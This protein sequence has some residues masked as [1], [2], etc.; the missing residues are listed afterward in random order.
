MP[1]IIRTRDC[2]VHFK[3]DAFPVA[4]APEMLQR[5]WPGS[6]GVKWA[7]STNDEFCVTYSDGRYGGFLLWGS[8][9]SSD[10][11]TALTGQQVACGH[12]VFCMGGWLISTSTYEKYTYASRMGGGPLVPIVYTASRR[13]VFSLRGFWTIEDEWTLSGDP[14]APNTYYLAYVVQSPRASNNFNLVLQT[15]I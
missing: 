7:P 5:G 13:L 2:T 6:Q 9:E 14:R 12:A 10:Q 15:A 8:D 4:L 1:E 11:F 3:G